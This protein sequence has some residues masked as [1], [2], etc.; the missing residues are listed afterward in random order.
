MLIHHVF[1]PVVVI[2]AAATAFVVTFLTF[3][4]SNIT[5]ITLLVTISNLTKKN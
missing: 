1:E 4:F 3:L 2:V 5:I